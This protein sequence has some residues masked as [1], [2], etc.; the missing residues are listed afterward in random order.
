[1]RKRINDRL[2]A[3]KAIEENGENICYL[4]DDLKHDKQLA[5]MAMSKCGF[6]L[7]TLPD[8]LK[9]DEEVIRA[10]LRNC[11]SSII[12]TSSRMQRLFNQI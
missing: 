4:S 12:H 1:M 2:D 8:S 7:Y 6:C 3:I 9:D 5:I 10:A 11:P